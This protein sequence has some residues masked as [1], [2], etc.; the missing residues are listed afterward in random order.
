MKKKETNQ[1]NGENGGESKQS[2]TTA[3]TTT[4]RNPTTIKDC[5]LKAYID[6]PI[7]VTT[8]WLWLRRL[9]FHYDNRKKSFF[10]DGHERPDVAFYRND[11]CSKYLSK[12]EPRTHRWIQ[13]TKETVE[14][15]KS[16]RRIL[17]DAEQTERGYTYQ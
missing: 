16:E 4:S 5:L 2:T 14:K 6:L 15:W 8:T 17:E 9:G 13:V 3:T 12:L 1:E 11:F 7:S 10:V